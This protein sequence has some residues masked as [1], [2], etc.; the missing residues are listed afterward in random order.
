[1]T[2]WHMHVECWIT[3]AKNTHSEYVVLI[4]VPL[5]Q[6]LHECY[7]I[8]TLCVL[9]N[10][11]TI[12]QLHG[13]TASSPGYEPPVSSEEVCMFLRAGLYS[14]EKR[15]LLFVPAIKPRFL[16]PPAV[17]QPTKVLLLFY[18]CFK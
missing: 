14:L 6:C 18:V 11:G 8:R 4:A 17:P 10:F 12:G 5:Q 16:C 15:N 3:E 13:Q 7:V 2:I 1:M 9:F